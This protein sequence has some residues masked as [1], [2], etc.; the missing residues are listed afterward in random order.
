[1]LLDKTSNLNNPDYWAFKGNSE[2]HHSHSFIRYPAM[3]VPQMQGELIDLINGQYN[4]S[5]VLDPFV[6]SGTVL[7]ESMFRG[8][9]FGGVDIN[10]LAILACKV[11]S[12]SRHPEHLKIQAKHLLSKI[13]SKNTTRLHSFQKIDKWFQPNV[14]VELSMIKTAIEEESLLW[15]RRFF[16]LT[17]A[18]TVRQTSNSRTSTYKLHIRKES[19]IKKIQSPIN[20]FTRVLQKSVGEYNKQFV[21][22]VNQKL[23]T[24]A[25][26]Y[27]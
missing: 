26:R 12:Y 5:S 25:C 27:Q 7:S 3:M 11:K 24:K 14:K 15:I 9:N 4:I 8:L 6:G 20:V 23:I 1:M 18:E 2:R 19:D 21:K 13:E 16:W 10:P 17:L 22:L